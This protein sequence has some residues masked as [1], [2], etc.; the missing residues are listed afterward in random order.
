MAGYVVTLIGSHRCLAQQPSLHAMTSLKIA[1]LICHCALKK[2]P[3]IGDILRS[4]D[5]MLFQGTWLMQ[6]NTSIF[7][8]LND[9][10]CSSSSSAVEPGENLM[11][12]PHGGLMILWRKSID[13]YMRKITNY[14]DNRI[15]RLE[16]STNDRCFFIFI[17]FL[18]LEKKLLN[19]DF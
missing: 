9:D 1:S 16:V 4:L 11:V 12:R 13:Y 15:L 10:F 5:L 14:G 19:L 3:I 17:G 7:E 2:M 8:N 6:Q 18:F